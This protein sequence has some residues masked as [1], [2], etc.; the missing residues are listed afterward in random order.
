MK[1]GVGQS[2]GELEARNK[3]TRDILADANMFPVFFTA[4]NSTV[5]ELAT[6]EGTPEFKGAEALRIGRDAL[7]AAKRLNNRW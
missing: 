6:Y 7:D 4:L 3:V 5:A 2:G 1:E